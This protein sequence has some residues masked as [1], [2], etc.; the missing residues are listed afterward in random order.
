MISNVLD[1]LIFPNIIMIRKKENV[2]ISTVDMR[3]VSEHLQ[4][5]QHLL[6][7]M[8]LSFYNQT[9]SIKIIKFKN[10]FY[11]LFQNCIKIKYF[12]KTDWYFLKSKFKIEMTREKKT[13]VL[14]ATECV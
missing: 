2:I 13:D 14:N 7:L 12:L 9:N 5:Q 8:I 11:Q 10:K 6:E 4:Q 3:I 1:S